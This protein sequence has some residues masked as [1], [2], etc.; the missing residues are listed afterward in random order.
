MRYV[1]L[2]SGSDVRVLAVSVEVELPPTVDKPSTGLNDCTSSSVVRVH[3]DAMHRQK[4]LTK[5]K[6]TT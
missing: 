6:P 3:N 5:I 2:G 4:C 1:V